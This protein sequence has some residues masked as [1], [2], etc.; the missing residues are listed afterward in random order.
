M[1]G[2]VSTVR[3]VFEDVP[4]ARRQSSVKHSMGDTLMSALAMFSLKYPSLLKFDEDVRRGE[5]DLVATN[6]KSLYSLASV[7]S[8]SQMRAI[9]DPLDPAALR[10]AFRRIL[11]GLQ[12]AGAMREMQVLDG[13]LLVAIDG[14]GSYASTN[15]SCEC[16]LRKKRSTSKEKGA[17]HGDT[18]VAEDQYEGG[19]GYED[20]REAQSEAAKLLYHHQMVA[21]VAVHP[22]PDKPSLPM[23]VEPISRRDGEDKNDCEHVA[24]GR[25]LES[26]A[27]QF[28]KQRLLLVQDGLAANGP[29]IRRVLEHDMDFLIVARQKGNASR[30]EAM[31]ARP[32]SEMPSW[33]VPADKERGVLEHGYRIA[34]AVPLNKSH[35]DRLV[36][37]LE[38]WEIDKKGR[39]HIWVWVTNLVPTPENAEALMRAG[40][41]RWR[42]ENHTFLTLK[43]QGYHFMH[44]YGHGKKNLQS[45]LG[46][47]MV[48]ALLI[49]QVQIGFCRVFQSILVK[50][51]RFSYLIEK[52]RAIFDLARVGS[53]AMFLSLLHTPG[54]MHAENPQPLWESRC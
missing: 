4:D 13:R 14:T 40:R 46:T 48:L 30:F 52:M 26:L 49:D 18:L 16:C 9:L 21:A 47:L 19:D 25:L 36:N 37:V 20:E 23:N 17:A 54:L 7:P 35:P 28:P 3:S 31:R 8:D 51:K 41:A 22:D 5:S 29:H 50:R 53:R 39:Q 12:R 45:V 43:R 24:V 15:V 2:L 27:G 10:P 33:Q 11:A 1:P 6:L 32:E 42:I 44:C 34:Y 38:Y